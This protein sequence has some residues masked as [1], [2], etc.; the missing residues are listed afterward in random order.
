MGTRVR[1]SH[2]LFSRKQQDGVCDTF[3]YTMMM[4]RACFVAKTR[5]HVRTRPRLRHCMRGMPSADDA[6]E[7]ENGNDSTVTEANEATKRQLGDYST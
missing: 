7:A 3:A 1:L 5:R 6:F 2:A 4:L